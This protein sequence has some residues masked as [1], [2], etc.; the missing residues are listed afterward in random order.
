MVDIVLVFG[1]DMGDVEGRRGCGDA[2][3]KEGLRSR[4]VVVVESTVNRNRLVV[5][6][7]GDFLGVGRSSRRGIDMGRRRI[8]V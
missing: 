4:D 7:L 8:A 3:E 2:L 1:D 5:G 6:I